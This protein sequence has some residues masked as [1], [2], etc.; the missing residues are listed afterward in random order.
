MFTSMNGIKVRALTPTKAGAG[1]IAKSL[2][3]MTVSLILV[4]AALLSNSVS[5]SGSESVDLVLSLSLPPSRCSF[6]FQ[7]K[8]FFED[9]EK[10][11]CNDQ[12]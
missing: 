7:I 4:P 2:F 8:K 5:Y 9:T 12:L 3:A 11:F 10:S 6:S 1:V